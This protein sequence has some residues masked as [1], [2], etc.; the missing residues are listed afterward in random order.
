MNHWTTANGRGGNPRSI[1]CLVEVVDLK[2]TL[3]A[4]PPGHQFFQPGAHLK[5]QH[6]ATGRQH[7]RECHSLH[8]GP[9]LNQPRKLPTVD[10]AP[11]HDTIFTKTHHFSTQFLTMITEMTDYQGCVRIHDLFTL[12]SFNPVNYFFAPKSH[13]AATLNASDRCL[14]LTRGVNR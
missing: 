9:S 3:C 12:C 6:Q 5:R 7:T 14:L 8:D 13:S 2:R 10:G 4:L 11:R 1:T